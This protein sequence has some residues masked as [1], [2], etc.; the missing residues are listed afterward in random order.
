MKKKLIPRGLFGL[1]LKMSDNLMEWAADVRNHMI[2][3]T[4]FKL[5]KFKEVEF[6]PYQERLETE[7]GLAQ[8]TFL[9]NREDQRRDFINAG[10]IEVPKE[11]RDYGIISS[12]IGNEDI[13][14]FQTTPDYTNKENLTYIGGY[15]LGYNDD[16][17]LYHAGSHAGELYITSDGTLVDR[18][19]DYNNYG[20]DKD[21]TGST[22]NGIT[23]ILAN[24]LDKIGSPVVVTSGYQPVR[25]P[26]YDPYNINTNPP[27][28]IS[29]VMNPETNKYINPEVVKL[30]QNFVKT[31]NLQNYDGQWIQ[32]LPEIVV[33][34]KH[35]NGNK[36]ILNKRF[37]K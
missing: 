32:T 4:K 18:K 2:A 25:N 15:G 10:Y 27:L 14:I 29:D 21:N 31:H 11:K 34:P 9:R 22:Y 20:L 5:P 26:M 12:K 8:S 19:L 36:L 35:K 28:T 37:R 23:Q 24:L 30:V 6:F 3:G 33:I 16:S 7:G 13:P 1:S 17:Q